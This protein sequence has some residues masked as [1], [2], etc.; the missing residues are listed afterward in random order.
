MKSEFLSTLFMFVLTA[1]MISEI[2]NQASPT[3]PTPVMS[4]AN[5]I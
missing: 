2:V 1:F 4:G 3:P 5:A